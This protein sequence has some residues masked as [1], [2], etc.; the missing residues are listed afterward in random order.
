MRLLSVIL[1]FLFAVVPLNADTELQR[2]T[3][4]A[5]NYLDWTLRRVSHAWEKMKFHFWEGN[6][7]LKESAKI[8]KKT[9]QKHLDKVRIK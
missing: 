9:I 1:L 6:N 2:Q 4:H 5:Q 8:D 3:E 7:R